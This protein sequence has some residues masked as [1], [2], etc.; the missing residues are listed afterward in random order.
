MESRLRNPYSS[1]ELS[2]LLAS[3]KTSSGS[4][5][6]AAHHVSSSAGSA[7]A[8]DTGAGSRSQ[9]AGN[10]MILGR[11]FDRMAKPVQ[12]RSIVGLM[13]L[14]GS[15]A[16]TGAG[17]DDKLNKAIWDI[18]SRASAEDGDDGV[19]ME[20]T[21]AA[22]SGTT[23][24]VTGQ[25]DVEDEWVRVLA[26]LVQSAMFYKDQSQA[27]EERCTQHLE[28]VAESIIRTICE[29]AAASGAAA[30]A[31][32]EG[33][34]ATHG[35]STPAPDATSS[36]GKLD[37]LHFVPQSLAL[38]PPS[39][40]KSHIPESASNNDFTVNADAPILKVDA[41]AEQS[42]ADEETKEL[43]NRE[44]IHRMAQQQQKLQGTGG[45]TGGRGRGIGG[46]VGAAGRG[47]PSRS[48]LGA[49]RGGR[50]LGRQSAAGPD[51]ASLFIR[52][53][54]PT[55]SGATLGRGTAKALL[56]RGR[57]VA[58]PGDG[59]AAA[60]R[61]RGMGRGSAAAAVGKSL[62]V[63]TK[64]PIAMSATGKR[65]GNKVP[66]G[67]SGSGSGGAAAA[68]SGGAAGSTG[69]SALKGRAGR[70][71]KAS[72]GG[73]GGRS[74]MMMID[75]AEVAKLNK[76]K[77]AAEDAATTSGKSRKRKIMEAAAAEEAAKRSK[78]MT[79]IAAPS[80]PAI[81]AAAAPAAPIPPVVAMPASSAPD[82]AVPDGLLSK[83]NKLSSSDR[84][85][86]ERFF[87]DRFNPTPDQMT[88]KMKI[89]EERSTDAETGQSL[90]ETLYLEL[91]YSTFGYKKTRK[92]KKK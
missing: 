35:T 28:S 50:G 49:G 91:D 11:V 69:A 57:G 84:S 82:A 21:E 79:G 42:R 3:S 65:P 15:S 40:V 74:K 47:V 20:D 48:A 77:K 71:M 75:S 73:M 59:R 86:V 53:K 26:S 52:S 87:S 29:T 43:E 66:T 45:G 7:A 76:E 51:T 23:N 8:A 17:G 92:I 46:R 36:K 30:G 90:K 80:S 89:N 1:L 70:A 16:G 78:S 5:S 85:R 32:S 68:A 12:L 38:L 39:K 4:A 24:D 44:R 18:L 25:P 19:A 81:S 55:T 33:D 88:Y 9:E 60:G 2:R 63:P 61:G 67:G 6:G 22:V 31:S 10:V 54:K 27:E 83:F 14:E 62:G 56:G 37:P 72:A 41:D 64:K 34:E 13:G 58:G